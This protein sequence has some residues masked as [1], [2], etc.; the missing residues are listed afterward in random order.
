MTG[1]IFALALQLCIV[2]VPLGSGYLLTLH[3]ILFTIMGF[4]LLVP[5][6]AAHRH[7]RYAATDAAVIVQPCRR[8]KW[9][10]CAGTGGG[11][12]WA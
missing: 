10:W 8:G 6:L 3:R 2:L 5:C 4:A 7:P 11:T 12:S 1:L 9:P